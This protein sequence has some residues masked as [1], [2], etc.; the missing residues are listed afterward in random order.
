MAYLSR[1][2]IYP[3]KALDG[4]SVETVRVLPSGALADDRRFAIFDALDQYVNGKRNPRV[5]RLR[6]SYNPVTNALKLSVG[7]DGRSRAFNVFSERRDLEE[8]LTE[9][10][11]FA[12][13]FRENNAVGFSD[14]TE[15]PGPTI[16]ATSTLREI[17]GWFGLTLEQARARFRTNLEVDGVPAFWEDR[18]YGL[19]GTTVRFSVGDVLFD[20][21][22]PCQRC[23]VPARDAVTGKSLPEFA[24]RFVEKRREHLPKWAE[25]SRFNHFYRVAI[26]TRLAAAKPGLCLS[27][28]D[29]I[30]V[31]G[32]TG[33]PQ[34]AA[35]GSA[36]S[37]WSGR[38]RVAGVVDATP[39]VR[40]FRLASTT[41]CKLPFTYLPGQY[42]NIE[43]LIEGVLHRRCYTI[44]STPTR[45]GYCE[46]TV[47]REE[48][49]LVSRYLHDNLKE[50]MELDV[51]GPGGRFTFTGNEASGLVLIGAGVGIT[52]LMSVIRYL[53]DQKWPGAIDLIYCAKTARDIIFRDELESLS[54]KSPNLRVT[55]TLTRERNGD[56]PGP[57]GRI[58]ADLLR[59]TVPDLANRRVHVCGPI[60]LA[61]D[62]TRM[63]K[64]SGVPTDQIR[65]E[66]FG[67]SMLQTSAATAV[68]DFGPVVGMV[69][70]SNSG[71]SVPAQ[72]GQT[73]I[74]A[75][76][77]VGI[78]IDRG[79][80][81]GV[82]GRCKV[83]LLSGAVTMDVD[84]ALNDGDKS[85]GF[86]LAC[87]AKP[88]GNVA[89]DA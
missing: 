33:V 52:P 79:C 84:D 41:N 28:G 49:G 26:N 3:V 53:T 47:K 66:A 87:Q 44:A 1:I 50:G 56:W 65:S 9:F 31:I 35:A 20:G 43:V 10:F 85:D 18:L 67:G 32:T 69:T 16:I 7:A 74:D 22:N 45:S 73:V 70:F 2:L 78:S 88:M 19:R 5:H 15:S 24:R 29:K 48:A 37:R 6:S 81:A 4:V 77:R 36:S 30:N 54:Q 83:R 39:T 59:K 76:S 55:T 86:V 8:W 60:E 80:L 21:I 62:M 40:T 89:I 25:S 72:G 34:V 23:V 42:L 63:L 75:A 71:K 57:R 64:E 27:T 46:V 12:V 68:T 11:G 51:S 61:N 14:D 58:T 82:C 38:L 17:A 13:T